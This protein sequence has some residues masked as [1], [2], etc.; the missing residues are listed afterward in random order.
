[1]IGQRELTFED[2]KAI[3][4]RRVW[5]IVVPALVCATLALAVS[6]LL[7]TRYTSETVVLVEQP[8]VPSDYVK[9][10]VGGDL[11]QRLASMR[12]QILSRTR[13]QQIIETFGLYKEE[14]NR[15]MEELV[16]RLHESITVTPLTPMA[17]TRSKDLPGFTV[18]VVAR[19]PELAQQICTE[20]TS[21]FMRQNLLLR[22]RRA[23]DTNQFLTKLLDDSKAKLNGQDS[24]LADFKRRYLGELPDDA[25]TNL[26]LLTGLAS[27]L[28]AVTQALNRAQQDKVFAESMLNQ[29]LPGKLSPSGDN[30]VT[31]RRQLATLQ[32]ELDS[33][34]GRYTDDHPDVVKTKEA[35]AQLQKRIQKE[36]TEGGKASAANTSEKASLT[37]DSPQVQQL[38]AQLRQTEVTIQQRMAEQ[39]RLQRDISRLQ[40]K[41]Q[42]SPSVEQEYKSLTRD[43]QTAL[44]IY[45]E[46]LKKQSDSE[47]ATDLE[48]RQQGEQFRVLDPPSL[49][50]KPTFPNRILFGVGGLVGGLALGLG[51]AFVLELQDTTLRS[52]RDVEFFLKLPTLAMIPSI[53]KAGGI[54][55]NGLPKSSFGRPSQPANARDKV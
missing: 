13:L 20:I 27:Q 54:P 24:K 31:L 44:G 42:L 5:V 18:G 33:F 19:R 14:G 9:S 32:S 28:E 51:I 8:T 52:D 55:G 15:P 43:Y 35:I 39:S 17:E 49:P 29:Q 38:R 11:S 1:M 34:H 40:A 36:D 48:R 2:Y 21:I 10:V 4:R 47:M 26:N 3:A 50:Q 16:A 22:Q 37:E 6:L 45:N 12:E 23:E 30:P 25:Q 53:E 46:L 7:P 41:L